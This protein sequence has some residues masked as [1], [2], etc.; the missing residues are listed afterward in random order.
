[1]EFIL[2]YQRERRWQTIGLLVAHGLL[3]LFL[4]H[5]RFA[6]WTALEEKT[7]NYRAWTTWLHGITLMVGGYL[8]D[9][10][11]SRQLLIPLIL[12]GGGLFLILIV[13]SK[14]E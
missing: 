12:I 11:G 10:K 9:G 5:G 13:Q 6:S 14:G 7:N 2:G 3:N 1:M 4:V 8:Y